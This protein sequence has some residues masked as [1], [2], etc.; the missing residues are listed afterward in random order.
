MQH[1]KISRHLDWIYVPYQK[2]LIGSIWADVCCVYTW[3]E[4]M[5]LYCLRRLRCSPAM[6]RREILQVSAGSVFLGNQKKLF[7]KL[8]SITF[9]LRNSAVEIGNMVTQHNV[10][11][12]CGIVLLSAVSKR[13]NMLFSFLK[14]E[15]ISP[16]CGWIIFIICHYST[17]GCPIMNRSI[18]YFHFLK[19]DSK[20]LAGLILLLEPYLL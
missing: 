13:L 15:G 9:I 1:Y 20:S 4:P 3:F 16:N 18:A 17:N 6:F 8:Q 2:S 5:S 19:I 12:D 14:I 7:I 11:C 10:L